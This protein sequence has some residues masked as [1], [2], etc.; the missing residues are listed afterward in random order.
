MKINPLVL[1]SLVTVGV[2]VLALAVLFPVLAHERDNERRSSCQ[3]N[4]KQLGLAQAQYARDYDGHLPLVQN[5]TFVPVRNRN[6]PVSP[7]GAY[8]WADALW[9][10]SKSTGL[11]QCPSDV[12]PPGNGTEVRSDRPGFIDYFM[13]ARLSGAKTTLLRSQSLVLLGDGIGDERGTA[14]YALSEPPTQTRFCSGFN[15]SYQSAWKH[16]ERANFLFLD[17]HVKS[18]LPHEVTATKGDAAT[19]AP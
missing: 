4:L 11:N 19:F 7:E 16:F 9:P 17:G 5:T 10:Y 12:W 6:S 13:N 18:L 14:R 1:K 15:N 2:P 8:E 3:S